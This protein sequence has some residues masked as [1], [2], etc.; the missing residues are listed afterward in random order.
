[1]ATDKV[2]QIITKLLAV[3]DKKPGTTVNLP[4][5][6]INMLIPKEEQLLDIYRCRQLTLDRKV[7]RKG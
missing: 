3:R 2:D 5:D 6:D 4:S 7:G 1:M